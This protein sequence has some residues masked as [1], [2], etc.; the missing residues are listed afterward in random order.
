MDKKTM[1]SLE[2]W[3]YLYSELE[4]ACK[5]YYLKNKRF[6]TYENALQLLEKSEDKR[7]TPNQVSSEL[8]SYNEFFMNQQHD[9]ISDEKFI[10]TNYDIFVVKHPRYF[11]AAKHRHDY[12]EIEYVFKGKAEQTVWAGTSKAQFTLEEGSFLIMPPSVYHSISV[13]DDSIVFNIMLRKTACKDTLLNTLPDDSDL[14]IFFTRTLY[15]DN[16]MYLVLKTDN[17]QV[18][19]DSFFDITAENFNNGL[20]MK[21][22]VYLKTSILFLNIL[23][24]TDLSLKSFSPS[25]H[26]ADYIPTIISFMEQNYR[27]ITPQDIAKKFNFSLTHIGRFFKKYTGKTLTESLQSIRLR[28]ACK[29]L[30]ETSYKV[31]EIASLIGYAEATTFTKR[32]KQFYNISPLQYRQMNND[33]TKKK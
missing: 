12:Y 27:S 20:Y 23:R 10:N 11:E 29:L 7:S 15:S 19:K 24:H 4:L 30:N 13:N 14:A 25:M 9:S 1:D 5:E 31:S 16:P 17:S 18:I 6:Y 28:E 21:K 3:I 32:F 8:F 22:L 2:Q 33:I 26:D